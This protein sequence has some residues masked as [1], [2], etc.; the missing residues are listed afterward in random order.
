MNKLITPEQMA[1]SLVA[2][3]EKHA[4]GD[5]EKEAAILDY[6]SALFFEGH[7]QLPAQNERSGSGPK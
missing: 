3:V 6:L 1:E 4:Q 5:P 7:R 2:L